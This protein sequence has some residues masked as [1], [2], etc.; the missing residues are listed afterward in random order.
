MTP[1]TYATP[2]AFKEALEQRLRSSGLV[3]LSRR[4][5]L[6]VFDR[7]LARVAVA[8]G[9]AAVLKGGVAL[10]LRLERARTTKDVDL[11]LTGTSDGLLPRLRDLAHLDLGDFMTFEIE[12]DSHYPEIQ[13]EGMRYEGLRFRVECRVAGKLYGQRFGLDVAFGDPIIGKPDEIVADDILAFAGIAPPMVRLYPVESHIAEKLHAYTLPRARPNSRVKDL[14]DL[15][16]LASARTI[17]AA[18]LRA[19]IE[20]TFAFRQTHA[21]PEMVPDPPG[22]W[23]TPYARMATEDQLP[24]GTLDELIARVRAFLDPILAVS[25]GASWSPLDWRWV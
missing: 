1:R 12:R 2:A 7:L 25:G 21:V 19:A 6:L 13:N 10:E 22:A 8:F 20:T 5:Q 16:L 9:D 17:Q 18:S 11:R 15:A 4:R 23:T 14:P 3:E 24:W